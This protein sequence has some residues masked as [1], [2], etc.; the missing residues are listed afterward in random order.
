MP[1][2]PS[3][4]P[5]SQWGCVQLT[6]DNVTSS[7]T[8]DRMRLAGSSMFP[9]PILVLPLLEDEEEEEDGLFIE[10]SSELV[11]VV[12]DDVVVAQ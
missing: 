12:D 2:P 11:D 5:S 7:A 4:I 10:V 3:R 1:P 8:F 6:R 9:T